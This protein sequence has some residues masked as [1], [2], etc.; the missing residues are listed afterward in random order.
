MTNSQTISTTRTSYPFADLD[1][2]DVVWATVGYKNDI[3]NDERTIIGHRPCVIISTK[4]YHKNFKTVVAVPISHGNHFPNADVEITSIP[5]LDGYAK[6]Y[7]HK[8]LDICR[9]GYSYIGKISNAELGKI[10]SIMQAF[11]K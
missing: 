3:K 6:P 11:F 5:E 4:Q 8:N 7:Q 1:R 2:G 10:L 9:R